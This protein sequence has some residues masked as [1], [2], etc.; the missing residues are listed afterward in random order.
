MYASHF[1][2]YCGDAWSSRAALYFVRSN[3]SILFTIYTTLG[4]IY[5][6]L[7]SHTPL[8]AKNTIPVAIWLENETS[9]YIF[10][11]ATSPSP[12]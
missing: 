12:R 2:D 4:R 9:S 10:R 11:F 3:A 6:V 7:E 5:V 8:D 1:K